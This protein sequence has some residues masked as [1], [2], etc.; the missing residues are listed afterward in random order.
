MRGNIDI[1]TV[2]AFAWNMNTIKTWMDSE[3]KNAEHK[4]KNSILVEMW[5]WS[6]DY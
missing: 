4:I 3:N 6:T 5:L 2:T 1:F